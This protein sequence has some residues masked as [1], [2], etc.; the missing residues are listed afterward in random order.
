MIDPNIRKE[1]E[2]ALRELEQG[3]GSYGE[4]AKRFKVSK[5]TVYLWHEEI[6]QERIQALIKE[7]SMKSEED[8][9]IRSEHLSL[10][11]EVEQLREERSRLIRDRESYPQ[12]KQEVR[13]LAEE[14]SRLREEIRW[15]QENLNQLDAEV[16]EKEQVLD[17]YIRVKDYCGKKIEEGKIII[18]KQNKIM[19]DQDRQIREKVQV[20][21]TYNIMMA[22]MASRQR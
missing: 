1:V 21:S 9:K 2:L 8:Q 13:E 5:T 22:F 11:G 7:T 4:T 6:L 18:S 17:E 20:I 14:R 3:R 19:E 15:R 16:R 12:L 10:S